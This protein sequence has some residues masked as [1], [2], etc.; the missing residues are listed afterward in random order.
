M[1]VCVTRE[2]ESMG[3]IRKLLKTDC[4]DYPS[5]IS[6]I[7]IENYLGVQY[8]E[9]VHAKIEEGAQVKM[10]ER[11]QVKMGRGHMPKPT[12]RK[13]SKGTLHN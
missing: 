9:Q 2:R 13:S 3:V 12:Q 5:H 11:A 8:Q 6:Q 10:G 7:T 1:C 4:N